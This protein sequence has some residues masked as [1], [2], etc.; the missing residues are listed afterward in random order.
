MYNVLGIIAEY[1]PLHNG[2]IFHIEQ[3][4][5]ACDADFT[6][7]VMSGNFVQR[8]DTS[9]INKWA[10]AEMALQNG[11]D[12]VIELPTVFA[13]SSAEIFAEGA[14]KILNS[15]KVVNTISFG[16]ETDDIGALNKIATV[17]HEEPKEYISLLNYELKKGN[18]FPKARENAMLM[19]LK[20]ISAYSGILSQPNNILGIEYL[21]A[22]RKSKSYIKPIMIQRANVNYND[23][24]IVNGF[25]SSTAI[26]DWVSLNDF[27]KINEVMPNS[28]YKLL[29]EDFKR[30]NYVQNF[31]KF[32]KEILY[33]LRKLSAEQIVSYPDVCKG[34]QFTIKKAASSCNNLHDFMKMVKSKRYT[35]TRI[36]RILIHILLGIRNR[37]IQ[38][39][40]LLPP[41]VR[42]LG[43][44]DRGK[45]LIS[46][47]CRKNPKLPVITSVKKFMDTSKNI[48]L[49]HLLEKDILAT[50]IYTLGYEYESTANLD[51]TQK[52]ITL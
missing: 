48:P 46:E 1:N 8:G 22:L 29:R 10:K 40:K 5:N 20:D 50:N 43:F 6:V 33:Q 28:A 14:I 25:A 17:L 45:S 30:G 47:I 52:L 49:K 18:S 12:L 41:Y 42:V 23:R 44:N 32:E 4:Q 31:Y 35:Q 38:I 15:L 26:R 34:L 19:Y 9:L 37:D 51:Y 24:E 2:H 16:I 36:Q 3:S 13:T 7:C 21:K 11:I 39:A 27:K